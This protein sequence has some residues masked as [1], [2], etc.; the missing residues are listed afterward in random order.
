MVRL[1]LLLDG[2]FICDKRIFLPERGYAKYTAAAKSLL[3]L[4]GKEKILVDTG[5]GDLPDKPGFEGLK[6]TLRIKRGRGQGIKA[7]LAKHGLRLDQI[8]AVINTH[9]HAAH[10]GNNNLFKDS[11]FYI[12]GDEFDFIDRMV[13]EDPNQ[14]SYIREKYD[15]VKDIV[16][17]RGEYNQRMKLRLFPHQG[18]LWGTNLS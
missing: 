12:A 4:S 5:I 9:L 7:Q 14:T 6:K 11:K 16:N 13:G 10:S 18:T 15:K 2:F 8:T 3:I 1:Q 17:V